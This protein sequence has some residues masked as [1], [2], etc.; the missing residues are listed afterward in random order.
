MSVQ[1]LMMHTADV[2]H[3]HRIDVPGNS[4][5]YDWTSR[6]C[7]KDVDCFVQPAS[8][9]AIE[10]AKIQKNYSI[11][12]TVFF[13]EDPK[14]LQYDRLHFHGRVFEVQAPAINLCEMDEAWRVDALELQWEQV[15]QQN[16]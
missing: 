8:S 3:R 10:I 7:D 4:A 6:P 16:S 12:H 2:L 15:N 11:S 13:N 9:R 14:L 5:K 1:S